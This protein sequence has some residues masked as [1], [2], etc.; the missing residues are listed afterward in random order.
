MDSRLIFLHHAAPELRGHGEEARARDGAG[1]KR[2]IRGGPSH[3]ARRAREGERT[4]S[5]EERGGAVEKSRYG[6][7]HARTVNRHRWMRR[8]S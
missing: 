3:P 6:A 4:E 8:G 7:P 5:S 1:S 2:G